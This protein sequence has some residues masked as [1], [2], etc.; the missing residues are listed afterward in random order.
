LQQDLLENEL[1][2]KQKTKHRA[3]PKEKGVPGHKPEG[4]LQG[5]AVMRAYETI[6]VMRPILSRIPKNDPLRKRGFQILRDWLK[7]CEGE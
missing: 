1:S 5:V 4:E 2:K 3:K 7:M 6:S